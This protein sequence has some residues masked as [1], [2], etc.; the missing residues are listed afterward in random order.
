MSNYCNLGGI[1]CPSFPGRHL[2]I[3]FSSRLWF[4]TAVT[5]LSIVG[6]L[7]GNRFWTPPHPR[8]SHRSVW[9]RNI[10]SF[11]L[12]MCPLYLCES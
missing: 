3:S 6:Y 8:V 11:M 2:W 1:N 4:G 7:P 12:A 9:P 5:A 10:W